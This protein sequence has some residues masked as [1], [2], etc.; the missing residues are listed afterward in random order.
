VERCPDLEE[1]QS[2]WDGVPDLAKALSREDFVTYAQPYC[3]HR[4]RLAE[5]RAL[6]R[7]R[8]DLG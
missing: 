1:A 8:S 6:V 3:N 7:P 4:Q 5:A 2:L